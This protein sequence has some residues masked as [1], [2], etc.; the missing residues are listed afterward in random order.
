MGRREPRSPEHRGR[1]ELADGR[2]IR[3]S[4][5][6][7]QRWK[8]KQQ[9]VRLKLVGWATIGSGSYFWELLGPVS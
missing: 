8:E 1:S 2:K 3:S 9:E 4:S 6:A 7:R 5:P